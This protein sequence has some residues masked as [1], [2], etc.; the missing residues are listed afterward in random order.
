MFAFE[1][2]VIDFE[3]WRKKFK[4]KFGCYVEVKSIRHFTIVK[5]QYWKRI[6]QTVYI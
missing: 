1:I 3:N 2:G 6:V 4:L 5:T